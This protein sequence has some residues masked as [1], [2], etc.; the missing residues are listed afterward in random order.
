MRGRLLNVAER[1]AGIHAAVMNACRTVC[2]PIGLS[3]PVRRTT[4]RTIRLAQ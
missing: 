2:G 3:I 1:D 4:R